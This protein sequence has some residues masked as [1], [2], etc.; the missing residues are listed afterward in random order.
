MDDYPNSTNPK[1]KTTPTEEA[2]ISFVVCMMLFISVA[3]LF[4][5]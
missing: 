4:T 2:I 3:M 5:C 1:L